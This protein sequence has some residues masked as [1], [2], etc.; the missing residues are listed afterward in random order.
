MPPDR[1]EYENGG[2]C[3]LTGENV[4]TVE[5]EVLPDTDRKEYE[6]KG[7]TS[8]RQIQQAETEKLRAEVRAKITA[9]IQEIV[10]REEE[11]AKKQ[12][13]EDLDEDLLNDLM[14]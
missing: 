7:Q 12:V 5:G 11:A 4:R 8:L 14:N 3:R 10:R 2:R 6:K 13:E 1:R 9:K